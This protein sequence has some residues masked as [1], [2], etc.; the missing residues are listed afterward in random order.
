MNIDVI[1]CCPA[2]GARNTLHCFSLH[3]LFCY[4]KSL[5]YFVSQEV[6]N[7]LLLALNPLICLGRS[8]AE[9]SMAAC[10]LLDQLLKNILI[11]LVFII[12]CTTWSNAIQ[13]CW[14]SSWFDRIAVLFVET[15]LMVPV[16]QRRLL[17]SISLSISLLFW[18]CVCHSFH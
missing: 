17:C 8:L 1:N 13:K 6:I 4:G 15:M 18:V 3:F 10:Y 5:M 7:I 11:S 16:G 2:G 9:S 14:R 12:C